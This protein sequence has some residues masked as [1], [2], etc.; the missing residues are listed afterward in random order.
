MRKASIF[1]TA[2]L[3]LWLENLDAS[4]RRDADDDDGKNPRR[5]VEADLELRLPLPPGHQTASLRMVQKSSARPLVT[6]S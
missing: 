4:E 1:S 6:K 5:Q 3:L 2:H